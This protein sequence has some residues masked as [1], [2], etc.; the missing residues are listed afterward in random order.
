MKKEIW[1][2]LSFVM[3]EKNRRIVLKS[4]VIPQTP[5][6][7]KEDTKLNVKIIS[8]ALRELCD[9]GLAACK[10]PHVKLGRIYVLTRKGKRVLNL[11]SRKTHKR[12]NG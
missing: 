4:L 10:T 9:E 1:N 3:R 5:T 8:R 6:S 12:C 11:M 7:I 2:S